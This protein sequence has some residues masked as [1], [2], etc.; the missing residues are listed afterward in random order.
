M[1]IDSLKTLLK[2][3]Q[4]N[5]DTAKQGVAQALV[6]E[7]IAASASSRADLRIMEEAESA[8]SASAGDEAVEIYA[9][10]LPIGREQARRARRELERTSQE[11]AIARS[12]LV[13]AKNDE[14]AVKSALAQEE[15]VVA[16]L[17]GRRSQEELD[18]A[19]V[20]CGQT[21]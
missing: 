11:V 8:A 5:V 15:R 19:G 4:M 10:W 20:R 13:L 6:A 3:R 17:R 1:R 7:T 18:E 12:A 2:L 21:G 9:R 14:Q 16:T